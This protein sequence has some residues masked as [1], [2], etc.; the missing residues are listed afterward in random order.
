MT[1]VYPNIYMEVLD[2]HDKSISPR[3]LYVVKQPGRSLMVDTAFRTAE[4]M[5]AIDR[6]LKELQIPYGELDVFIT[7]IHPDHAGLAEEMAAKGARLYMNPAEADSKNDLMH[8]YLSNSKIRDSSLRAIGVTKEH[9]PEVY[10]RVMEYTQEQ[11]ERNLSTESFSFQPIEPGETLRYGDF[12]F[13]VLSLR[14]HTYGQL[15][16]YDKRHKVFFCADQLM[17]TISPIVGSVH[18]NMALLEYY[19]NSLEIIKHHFQDYLILSSHY[20]IITDAGREVDRIVFSYLDKCGI[21]KRVLEEHG[22]EMTVR[23]VG[24]HAYGRSEAPPEKEQFESCA[25]IWAKTFS[26]LEYL[27]EEG[28]VTRVERDGTLY[29]TGVS[30]NYNS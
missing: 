9:T 29:W 27:Y 25:M 5:E 20:D 1:E 23:Q 7:H 8:C 10:W 28:F 18:K 19:M 15:G 6:M 4:C 21:M 17:T 3:N 11:H 22:G 2:F 14:G 30:Y 24:V 13:Q 12:A 26:C 16:L